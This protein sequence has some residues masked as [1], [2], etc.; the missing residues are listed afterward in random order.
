[1]KFMVIEMFRPGSK[2]AV[3]ARYEAKGRML[4]DGLH[5][6]DSWVSE[7]ETRCFQLMETDDAGLINV[8]I[9]NWSDLIDFEVVAVRDSPT[10]APNK[11]MENRTFATC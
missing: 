4:P 5:Y 2:N 7:D 11:T 10:K 6:I 1:M 9:E 3:Y 8:W